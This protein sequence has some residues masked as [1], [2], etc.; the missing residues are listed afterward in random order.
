MSKSSELS[1]C[2][3][4]LESSGNI[5]VLLHETVPTKLHLPGSVDYLWG[6]Y[7]SMRANYKSLIFIADN[8]AEECCGGTVPSIKICRRT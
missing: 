5:L 4:D 8:L 1:Q 7:V 2:D 6:G 3:L